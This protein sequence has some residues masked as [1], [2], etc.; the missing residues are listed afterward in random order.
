MT[1]PLKVT[2]YTDP[3][4]IW[5]WGCEPM[6]RRLEVVYADVVR[7]EV[8]QGGLSE[9]FTPLRERSAR[10]SRRRWSES[11]GAFFRAVASQRRMPRDPEPVLRE[12]ARLNSPAPARG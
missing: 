1:E 3:H 9:R 6:R 4:N 7:L 12:L 2:W 8:R 11:A 10:M 5:C